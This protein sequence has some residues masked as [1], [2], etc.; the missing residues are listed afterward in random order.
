MSVK[1]PSMKYIEKP[2]AARNR[3][4]SLAKHYR[5]S[6]SKTGWPAINEVDRAL[7][8][9]AQCMKEIG[10]GAYQ[11]KLFFFCG[12]GWAV[13]QMILQSSSVIQ[14]QVKLEFGLTTQQSSFI[15]SAMMLGMLF[16]AFTTGMLSDSL[17]RRTLF[18]ASLVCGG[19]FA[20]LQAFSTSFLALIIL[21]CITGFGIGGNFPLVAPSFLEF[22]P[23]DQQKLLPLLSTFR[24]I[25]QVVTGLVAWIIIPVKL[26]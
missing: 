25:G 18:V 24:P 16:S 11:W 26:R 10:M 19:L 15:P 3:N 17:G 22:I 23:A 1:I 9:L 21:V 7:E 8:L 2:A 13:D 14:L 20:A 5:D 6:M 12:F 4:N